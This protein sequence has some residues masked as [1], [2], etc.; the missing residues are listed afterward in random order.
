MIR[1][2]RTQFSCVRWLAVVLAA[3]VLTLVGTIST[4]QGSGQVIELRLDG[5][6]SP[7]SSDFIVRGIQQAATGHAQLIVITLDTPGGL[8]ASMR[9]IVK[10]ILASPI[11]VA[12]YVAPTGA[13]A[14]SAGTFILY[15]SHIAA[16]APASNIGA[17]TPVQIGGPSP[18]KTS[19]EQS[20]MPPDD[21]MSRKARNDA[22]AYIRSLAQL[23]DRNVQFAE[24]AVI[25]A[26]SMS[27]REA[28]EK[29]VI[30]VIAP[31]LRSMLRQL[32]G[33]DI[34]TTG[35]R[36]VRLQ[37]ADAPV[38]EVEPDWRTK[39]LLLIA[40]PQVAV[41]LMMIGVYGLFYEVTSPGLAGPGVA[42][43]ISLLLAFYA[44]QLL[45]VNWAGVGLI[46][47]GLSLMIAEVFLPSFGI[48]G[49]G[50]VVAFVLGGVLLTDGDI[51][52][53]D[54]GLP[55]IIGSALISVAILLI[56]GHLALRSY[57]SR[58]VSGAE[59]MIGQTG[60]VTETQGDMTYA[61]VQGELW[62]VR[63]HQPL[64]P[65]L[66][67]RVVSIDGLVL[68][69]DVVSSTSAPAVSRNL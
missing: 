67:I 6:I 38:S 23:R 31:D 37:T 42:G 47:L 60:T 25:D 9:S 48:A 68:A 57:R 45:P 36:V 40:N 62:K 10:A 55:F 35:D 3:M 11:P 69:V 50:G 58:V 20:T 8:V 53:F 39:L 30:D 29:N 33:R 21:A 18:G 63:S 32:D 43:L 7:A 22:A 24:Q 28:L 1:S 44:F 59:Y 65:G 41:I 15:A 26:A 27:A 17:A 66:K 19:K 46:F 12:T 52:G 64:R 14:A 51:P 49:A 4:G 13:R 34:R 16:M 5:V 56:I 54:L 2:T 61:E